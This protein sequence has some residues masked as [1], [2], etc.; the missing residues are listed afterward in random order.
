MLKYYHKIAIIYSNNKIPAVSNY[1]SNVR[2][3][4]A[5]KKKSKKNMKNGKNE[6]RLSQCMIVKNEEKNIE[7]ALKWAKGIAF[8]QIVVDTGS[9]DRTVEIA[10]KMGAKVYNF[11]WIN[12]FSAAKNYAIEQAKGNWIAFLDA[13]EYFSVVDAKKVMIYLKNIMADPDRR[14]SCLALNCKISNVDDEG[15]PFSVLVQ[16]RVFRNS[17]SVRY[18][19]KIH[20][21][22]NILPSNVLKADEIT[23]IHT[24]YTASA[25]KETGK[26]NRNIELIQ[27]ELDENPEDPGLMIYL[28]DSLWIGDNQERKLQALALY[29]KA[30]DSELPI[31]DMLKKSAYLRILERGINTGENPKETE[32]ICRRALVDFPADMDFEYFLSL[33]LYNKGEKAEAWELIKGVEEKLVSARS[34][35]DARNITANP[36]ELFTRMVL[37]AQGLGDVENV[38]RYASMVLVADKT[39]EGVLGPYI[40]MLLN[41]GVSDDEVFGL[42]SRMYDFDNPQ[43]LLVIARAAKNVGAKDFALKIVEMIRAY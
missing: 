13:D 4:M 16:E 8:E 2:V 3:N 40:G 24:G 28:A 43:D 15:K 37:I 18:I 25:Y 33:I 19:G 12:D 5:K 29:K 27:A 23:I 11:E 9:T 35:D 21:K 32:A 1:M 39:Q 22:L 42:L 38:I 14:Q 26:A 34:L 20:E 17:P 6:I 10:K 36:N 30:L 41:N 7:K 31:H